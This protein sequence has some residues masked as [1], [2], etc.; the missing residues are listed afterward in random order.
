MKPSLFRMIAI[1]ALFLYTAV[2]LVGCGKNTTAPPPEQRNESP[3][4]KKMR[5]DKQG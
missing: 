4:M 1:L 3:D 5:T 2:F